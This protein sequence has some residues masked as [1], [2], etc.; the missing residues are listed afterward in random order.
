MS[1]PEKVF[2][3]QN[4]FNGKI[5]RVSLDKVTLSNDKTA[6]REVVHHNGGVCIAALT[7]KNELLFVKQYRYPM[8]KFTLELPAGTLED[9]NN[10]LKEGIRELREETGAI[11][12]D[13]VSLGSSY[14]SPGFCSEIIH[15]FL[16][17]VDNYTNTEFD[18]DEFIEVTKIPIEEAFS[19]V[20]NNQIYDAKTQIGILKAY[21]FIKNGGY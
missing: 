13:F 17:K 10:P 5:I 15:I 12:K 21:W 7:P 2:T 1:V 8:K 11:G 9:I 6:T 3:S 19:M 16:C 14:S 18:D 20:L 4:I